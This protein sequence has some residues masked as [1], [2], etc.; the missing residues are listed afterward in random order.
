M[1]NNL[2]KRLIGILLLLITGATTAWL[3][4]SRAAGQE[5][6]QA[7]PCVLTIGVPTYPVVARTAHLEGV[8]HIKI[9]TDG[10]R[11]TLAEVQDGPKLLAIPAQDNIRTWQFSPHDPTTFIV[12]Y[13]YKLVGVVKGD[14]STPAVMLR[15]P[16]EVEVS[17]MP[18]ETNDPAL[19]KTPRKRHSGR[20]AAV[21][22]MF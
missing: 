2:T 15:L 5:P 14:T 3:F 11:V 20:V 1:M 4:S 18:R 19:D 6:R 12:T 22:S 21:S 7:L 9:T 10:R 13:R 8:V 17:A 16:A